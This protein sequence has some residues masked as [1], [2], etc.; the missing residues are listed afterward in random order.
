MAGFLLGKGRWGRQQTDRDWVRVDP[1]R[2]D[3]REDR[4]S[5]PP[6]WTWP[7]VVED[8]AIGEAME[9]PGER[10]RLDWGSPEYNGPGR[11]TLRRSW[12]DEPKRNPLDSLERP[13]DDDTRTHRAGRHTMMVPLR[14]KIR[15]WSPYMLQYGTWN[16]R[17]N[18]NL[19]ISKKNTKQY[20]CDGH[21][22]ENSGEVWT[23]SK[24][25]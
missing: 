1:R 7:A 16:F 17:K 5:L 12:A 8:S 18:R 25:F 19:N 10:D 2:R 15:F 14:D 23:T 4:G 24:A 3:E 13:D 9:H 22:A 21:W 6:R 20:F 11:G